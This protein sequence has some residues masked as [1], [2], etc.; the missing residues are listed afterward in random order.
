[1]LR[2]A[3]RL[4]DPGAIRLADPG[5]IRLADPAT[6]SLADPTAIHYPGPLHVR[7]TRSPSQ[8]YRYCV[9]TLPP[10]PATP[11]TTVTFVSRP[12]ASHRRRTR[13]PSNFRGLAL[14]LGVRGNRT[15][16]AQQE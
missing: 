7:A 11:G 16:L 12:P 6:N 14:R 10:S 8:P 1:M 4:A 15:F 2:R 5:A 9:V 13:S 3:I